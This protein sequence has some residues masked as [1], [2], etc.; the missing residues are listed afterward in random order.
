MAKC[1]GCDETCGGCCHIIP[2]DDIREHSVSSACWC[3]P[4]EVDDG[5]WVHVAAD[6]RQDFESGKRKPS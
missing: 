5:I 6:G 2:L 3:D 4:H 1:D